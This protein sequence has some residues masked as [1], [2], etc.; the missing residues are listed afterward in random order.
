ML[1][2]DVGMDADVGHQFELPPVILVVVLVDCATSGDAMVRRL[3]V[4][5]WC[6]PKS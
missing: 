3:I 4:K 1:F 5:L 6:V 2:E